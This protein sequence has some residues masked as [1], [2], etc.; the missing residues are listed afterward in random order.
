MDVIVCV[1]LVVHDKR[2]CI[3]EREKDD[4]IKTI[5]WRQKHK[6]HTYGHALMDV[7]NVKWNLLSSWNT[8]LGYG[9]TK[10]TNIQLTATVLTM[11]S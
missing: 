10:H 1:V 5:Y 2:V 6:L 4:V 11:I 3:V 9:F 7:D 8:P